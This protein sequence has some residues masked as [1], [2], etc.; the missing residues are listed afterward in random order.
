MIKINLNSRDNNFFAKEKKYME[1]NEQSDKLINSKKSIQNE[2]QKMENS[3]KILIGDIKTKIINTR[4]NLDILLKSKNQY[5]KEIENEKNKINDE[6]ILLKN[7]MNEKIKMLKKIK[8]N[9][10]NCLHDFSINNN[11][12]KRFSKRI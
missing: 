6:I 10:K 5:E 1:L 9:S 12:N 11:S 8:N 2:I 4:K 7:S 3:Y